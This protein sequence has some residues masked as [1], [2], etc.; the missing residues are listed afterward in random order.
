MWTTLMLSSLPSESCSA[1]LPGSAREVLASCEA[2]DTLPP[3]LPQPPDITNQRL[4]SSSSPPSSPPRPPPGPPNA[5]GTIA[6]TLVTSLWTN[7]WLCVDVVRICADDV[8]ASLLQKTKPKDLKK[9]DRLQEA[10]G[11]MGTGGLR[12]HPCTAYAYGAYLICQ[13]SLM[14]CPLAQSESGQAQ[15]SNPP[16][17]CGARRF[18]RT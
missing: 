11:F 13:I 2:K 3:P 12:R 5:M 4:G 17:W 16:Y 9:N 14:S 7:V 10:T 1:S 18:S 15:P 8:L 6:M